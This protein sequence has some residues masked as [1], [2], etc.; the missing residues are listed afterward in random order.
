MT[1]IDKK[2]KNYETL[3]QPF[4]SESK[5]DLNLKE[6]E[7][8]CNRMKVREREREIEIHK[9]QMFYVWK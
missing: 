8:K 3:A 1:M 2:M 9:K 4:L 7:W 5:R 6:E